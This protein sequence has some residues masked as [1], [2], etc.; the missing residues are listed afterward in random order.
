MGTLFSGGVQSMVLWSE[1][2]RSFLSTLA[3]LSCVLFSHPTF[4]CIH[5]VIVFIEYNVWD[6]A[7]CLVHSPTESTWFNLPS[8]PELESFSGERG[9]WKEGMWLFWFGLYTHFWNVV[10]GLRQ[11]F[12]QPWV[13]RQIVRYK[14]L[15]LSNCPVGW[16]SPTASPDYGEWPL[17]FF[18]SPLSLCIPEG[19]TERGHRLPFSLS[20][21]LCLSWDDSAYSHSSIWCWREPS[22]RIETL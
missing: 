3:S 13:A 20:Y 15:P 6:T 2:N 11:L 22:G 21:L 9:I 18:I 19:L 16:V 1:D 5:C 14:A 17:P 8:I 12:L 4:M 7:V 10:I